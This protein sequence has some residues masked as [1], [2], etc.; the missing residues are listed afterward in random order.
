[1]VIKL[2]S[3]KYLTRKFENIKKNW[4]G[5]YHKAVEGVIQ[6]SLQNRT[7]SRVFVMNRLQI[8]GKINEPDPLELMR[9]IK[10]KKRQT[11]GDIET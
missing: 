11:V 9:V 10:K 1:M 3:L 5:Y 2:D 6:G 4:Q 8:P 7:E